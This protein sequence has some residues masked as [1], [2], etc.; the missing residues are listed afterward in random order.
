MIEKDIVWFGRHATTGCDNECRK[1]WG[2]NYRP[3]VYLDRQ[4][5]IISVWKGSGDRITDADEKGY[6]PRDNYAYIPDLLLNIAPND[7]GTYEG[8]HAKP[9]WRL[10]KAD[11]MNKWCVRECERSVMTTYEL[12]NEKLVLP[13]FNEFRFNMPSIQ[14]I[15]QQNPDWKITFEAAVKQSFSI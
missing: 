3:R 14:E 10:R 4:G 13:D 15:V 9:E 2:A 11:K 6:E 1:A 7:P 8:G 12:P 5:N